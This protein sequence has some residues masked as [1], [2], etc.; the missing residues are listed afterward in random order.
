MQIETNTATIA[1]LAH[2]REAEN[3]AF[4]TFLDRQDQADI[5][6]KVFALNAQISPQIDCT[7]CGQC[8]K[9]LMVN[10]TQPEVERL[11]AH[12]EMTVE[13]T[14]LK[15]VE[16]SLQ[17]EMIMNTIPCHFLKGTACSVY[18]HRF[19][20]CREFPRLH[21]SGF[22]KRTFATFMHYAKCPIIFNVVEELK[23]KTG[24]KE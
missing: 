24:F 15:Y 11:S 23:V 3:D 4:R 19:T 16:T 12:L 10:I 13:A 22:I 7:A 5:D 17:G 2:L 21:R 18:E 14:K 20:E 6:E 9:V 8:C 1:A